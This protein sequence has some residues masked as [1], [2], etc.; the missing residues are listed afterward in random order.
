MI[1][2]IFVN[3]PVKDLKRSM[4]FSSSLASSST[5]NS[6]AI[7][8]GGVQLHLASAE[9][10]PPFTEPF[11]K[12]MASNVHRFLANPVSTLRRFGDHPWRVGSD[13]V[14]AR[15]EPCDSTTTQ[16]EHARRLPRWKELRRPR[17]TR[18]RRP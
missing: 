5:R 6:A 18:I 13:G 17:M 9:A 16:L 15:R 4:S 10:L 7:A 2:K 8:A 12:V 11:D 1:R 14:G 3:L